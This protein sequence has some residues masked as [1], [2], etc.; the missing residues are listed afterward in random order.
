MLEHYQNIKMGIIDQIRSME[1][2]YL[3]NLKVNFLD[4]EREIN[5]P[6]ITK[7]IKIESSVKKAFDHIMKTKIGQDETIPHDL[8]QMIHQ[9]LSTE[10]NGRNNE[11][12]LYDQLHQANVC[13]I[14]DRFITGTAEL[15]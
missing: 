4:N 6:M 12:P 7:N 15:N 8:L 5:V 1:N 14:C 9:S 3:M 2:P 13:V 11:I 10:H